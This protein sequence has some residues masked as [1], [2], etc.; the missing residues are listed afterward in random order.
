MNNNKKCEELSFNDNLSSKTSIA[1]ATMI[2]KEGENQ[3]I[4]GIILDN[5]YEK[6]PGIKY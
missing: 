1:N 2:M 4:C 6:Y 3:D 5:I